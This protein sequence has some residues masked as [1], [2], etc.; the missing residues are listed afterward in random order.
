MTLTDI[1]ERIGVGV[2]SV[3]VY[4]SRATKNRRLGAPRPGDLPPPDDCYSRTP[5]W[6]ETTIERWERRRPGQG[7]GGGRR[8]RSLAVGRAQ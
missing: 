5:V 8:P 7:A 4:H 3:R 6:R 2:E 1:A